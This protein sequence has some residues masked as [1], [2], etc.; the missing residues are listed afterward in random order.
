MRESIG[1]SFLLNFIVVFIVFIMAFLAATLS[2]YK[3]YRINN[4]ILHAVEKYEGYNDFSKKEIKDK[5]TSMGY[6]VD[7]IK[8]KSEMKDGNVTGTLESKSDDGYCIYKYWNEN[9]KYM[10]QDQETDIYYSYAVVSYM[11]M[12]VPVIGALL[13]LPVYSKT[14]NIYHFSE[15]S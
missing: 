8:C 11:R 14:Y 2:Y 10:N 1:T 6:Q 12:E 13:K 15:N 7:G 5:I 3:A 4:M 9:P